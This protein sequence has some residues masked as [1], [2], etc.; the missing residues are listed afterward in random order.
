M[1]KL[2]EHNRLLILLGKI[3]DYITSIEDPFSQDIIKYKKYIE[4]MTNTM[5]CLNNTINIDANLKEK[6]DLEKLE[7]RMWKTTQEDYEN[8]LESLNREL[9]NIKNVLCN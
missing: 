8:N 6:R 4:L 9:E 7:S 2:K 5:I 3:E 1:I